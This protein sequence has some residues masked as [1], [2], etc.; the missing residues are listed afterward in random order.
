MEFDQSSISS[1]VVH[2]REVSFYRTECYYYKAPNEVQY[3]LVE[4]KAQY[5]ESV[6]I[7]ALETRTLLQ[8][9]D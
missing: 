5:T 6:E 8:C 1:S 4:F 3:F 9:P 7:R 2:R